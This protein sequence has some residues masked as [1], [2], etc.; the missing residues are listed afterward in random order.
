MQ[1]FT[2]LS[3]L[4]ISQLY[5]QRVIMNLLVYCADAFCNDIM[6]MIPDETTESEDKVNG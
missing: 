5:S 6:E 2:G 4:G 1:V 3:V